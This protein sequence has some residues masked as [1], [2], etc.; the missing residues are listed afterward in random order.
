MT[1]E[2]DLYLRLSD[3]RGDPD[4]FAPREA[5]LRAEAARLG[6]HVARVVTE[7]DIEPD[8]RVKPASAFKRRKMIT[9]SGRAELRTVRPGFRSVLD[10]ITA[11]RAGAVLAE[12]LDRACRDPRDL[13]DLIDAC[14]A[15]GASARS[16]TGS[17]MLT[18][19][20][21]DGEVTM[22]R[23]MVTMGNKSSRDTRRRVA[24]QRKTTAEAGWYGGG[25]RPFGYRPDP[26]APKY[27]KTLIIV[28]AEA[29]VLAAAAAGVLA[30]VSLKSLARDLRAGTLAGADGRPLGYVPTVGGG[31]WSAEILR[32]AVRKATVAGLAAHTVTEMTDDGPEAKT[33]LHPA[34]W[35]AILDRE[36]W[37]S[38]CDIL[39]DPAR[40]TGTSNEP[41]WLLSGIAVCGPCGDG[42]SVHVT[43]GRDK[44]PSYVCSARSHLRRVAVPAD[45]YAG[46]VVAA[47]LA[48]RENADL[49][50]PP[51]RQGID[52][53]ALRR[54]AARLAGRKAALVRLNIAGDLDDAELA[55]GLRD[56]TRRQAKITG[57]LA[58]GSAPDPLAEFRDAADPAA[59]WAALPLAR[60]R[61]VLDLIA[62][63]TLLPAGRRGR[64]FDPDSIRIEP[65]QA[66]AA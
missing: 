54:E 55:A 19:G 39:G 23:V 4:G 66:A 48:K 5:A 24:G 64:G 30:G 43:G 47:I 26:A 60:R 50:R 40:R 27:A 7:N 49:L 45:D 34:K 11:G 63:V 42:T 3:F 25:P 62:T 56:I 61:A 20:G 31:P 44:S 36:V 2:C 22:A 8:G 57:Q 18:D 6:W 33:T 35:P 37:E 65:R 51:P 38:V 32:D 13:E 9:P 12:D 16:L 53:A 29:A 58:A 28:D 52:A 46:R 10:D 14:A 59:V 41:R 17:L 15:R 1:T 21:T